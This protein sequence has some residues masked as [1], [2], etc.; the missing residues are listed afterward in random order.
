VLPGGGGWGGGVSYF[1]LK[2]TCERKK[3]IQEALLGA[4]FQNEGKHLCLVVL[5]FVFVVLGIFLFLFCFVLFHSK[6]K[7]KVQK[8]KINPGGN[9]HG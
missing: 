8:G 3:S 2:V 7:G 4:W 6:R 1:N 9:L 5:F